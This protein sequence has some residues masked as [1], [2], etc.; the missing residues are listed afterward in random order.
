LLYYMF[1]ELGDTFKRS[2]QAKVIIVFLIVVA[3]WWVTM[4]VRGLT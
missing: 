2:W 4:F 1:R 3:V